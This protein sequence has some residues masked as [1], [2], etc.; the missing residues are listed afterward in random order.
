MKIEMQVCKENED[1][2]ADVVFEMD[3]EAKRWI[4]TI[5]IEAM[6]MKAIESAEITPIQP[7]KVTPE[8]TPEE[9]E[10]WNRAEYAQAIRDRNRAATEAWNAAAQ[11]IVE[12]GNGLGKISIR[13]AVEDGF[14][15]GYK[16]ATGAKK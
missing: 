5:G 10:E 12:H 6:L 3:E 15:L 1:G 9:E 13:Q 7:P 11:Y 14:L 16:F 8:V 4:M 2:S